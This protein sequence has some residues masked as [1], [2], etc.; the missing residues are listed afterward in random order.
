MRPRLIFAVALAAVLAVSPAAFADDLPK[1]AVCHMKTLGQWITVLRTSHD[2]GE[3]EIALQRVAAY[4]KNADEA[5]GPVLYYLQYG[6]DTG[7]LT[8]AA[9]T[10]GVIGLDA[11]HMQKGVE[12]LSRYSRYSSAPVRYQALIALTR[13][14]RDAKGAVR[15]VLLGLT[16]NETW[17]IRKAAASALGTIAGDKDDAPD[18]SVIDALTKKTCGM[19]DRVTEVRVESLHTLIHLGPP[20]NPQS[21]AT[22][23]KAIQDLLKDKNNA[24]NYRV[25]IWAN[26]A[27]MRFDKQD[28]DHVKAIVDQLKSP[29]YE[30][31]REAAE[32]MRLLTFGNISRIP[33]LIT[34]LGA[35]DQPG[36]VAEAVAAALHACKDKVSRQQ[37]D[38]IAG[39]L[40]DQDA[41][42]R[43][44]GALGLA[45]LGKQA[46]GY[47]P[48]LILAL[49][50]TDPSVIK[51]AI[52]TLM[53]V[54][55]PP[56]PAIAAL[57]Q[58]AAESKEASIQASAIIAAEELSRG[59]K[60]MAQQPAGG[61]PV[62]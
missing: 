52:T 31:R 15:E 60:K 7:V 23:A 6:R 54:A 24:K 43:C 59:P 41:Q 4:G 10:L 40:K 21:K 30:T 12:L 16:D 37:M 36:E 56:A 8:N 32:A 11:K 34:A 48:Q 28:D 38:E 49:K 35:V 13:I 1:D 58:L 29:E 18:A 47:V 5:I 19:N 2:Y 14:G 42:V 25:L 20:E 33:D 53:V 9:Y 46:N 51:S 50:D 26:M 45:V 27:F 55:D 62:P 44:H 22:A 39:L 3:V 57:K 17:E 61:K